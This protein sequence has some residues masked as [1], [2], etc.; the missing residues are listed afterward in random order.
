MVQTLS[1]GYQLWYRHCLLVIS[2]GTDIVYRLSVMVQTLSSGY[3]LWYRHCLPV[4]SYGTDIVYQLPVMVQTLSTGYQLW[5]RH[6]LPSSV[7]SKHMGSLT[8][9]KWEY[10]AGSGTTD[11]ICKLSLP[12]LIVSSISSISSVLSL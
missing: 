9:M 10:W 11:I 3:Q 1:T 6:C 4:I 5:Y 8:G 12:A 7:T 2:Y